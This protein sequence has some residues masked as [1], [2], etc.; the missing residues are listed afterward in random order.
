MSNPD[1]ASLKKRR[2]IV[3][4]SLTRLRTRLTNLE[5]SVEQPDTVDHAKRLSTKL[6]T[7]DTEFKAHHYAIV[8]LTD[9]ETQLQREQDGL[10]EHDDEV[11]QLAVRIQQSV[12]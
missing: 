9:D 2:G 1:L 12:S 11:S 6:D 5:S 4:A 8:D 3:K 7:L 10:D